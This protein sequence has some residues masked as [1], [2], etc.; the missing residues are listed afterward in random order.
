[1]REIPAWMLDAAACLGLREV[2]EPVVALRA[3][4]ALRSLLT[5]AMGRGASIARYHRGDRHAPP[6]SPAPGANRVAT[7]FHDP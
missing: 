7:L 3:L 6:P 5:E 2:P 4:A 1:M